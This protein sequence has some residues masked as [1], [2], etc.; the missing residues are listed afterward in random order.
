[1]IFANQEGPSP[2]SSNLYH[3]KLCATDWLKALAFF[4]LQSMAT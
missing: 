2:V 1:M 4:N 3:Q